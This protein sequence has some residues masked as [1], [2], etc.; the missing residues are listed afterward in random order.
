[1]SLISHVPWTSKLSMKT[2]A[3]DQKSHSPSRKGKV[4]IPPHLCL[5][6]TEKQTKLH[7]SYLLPSKPPELLFP[8][9]PHSAQVPFVEF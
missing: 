4:S 5:K 8:P 1:M 6:K 9:C 7:P 3:E 2:G